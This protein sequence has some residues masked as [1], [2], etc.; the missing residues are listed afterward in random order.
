MTELFTSSKEIIL[1]SGSP[2]RRAYFTE[3]GLLFRVVA[4]DIEERRGADETAEDYVQRLAREKAAAVAD[5][6]CRSWIVAA[7]TVVCLDGRVLE[8]P[9][10]PEEAVEM[11]QQLSG[12]RH[13]V[14]T[15]VCLLN[16]DE[17]VEEVQ[18]VTTRV[19]FWEVPR[20]TVERYV[21][22]GEPMDKAGSY[23][24]QGV[25]A[26][27]VRDICGSYSNVVGLPLC[28]LVEMLMRYELI[29]K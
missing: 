26:F 23:G 15:A 4:A 7:D 3:L 9:A 25:G 8:K 18:L 11:L 17:G 2:R 13:D 24:I 27:L 16:R 20:E 28:E 14:H 10:G 5:R 19:Q 6:L 22:T 12:R 1:A 21:A 29:G